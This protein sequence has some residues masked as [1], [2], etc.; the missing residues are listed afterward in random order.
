MLS[1]MQDYYGAT[2]ECAGQLGPCWAFWTRAGGA[3]VF[4]ETWPVGV[5]PDAVVLKAK[6]EAQSKASQSLPK[7]V[8]SAAAF[9]AQVTA[10]IV[11]SLFE[12]GFRT[13]TIEQFSTGP[14]PQFSKTDLNNAIKDTLSTY[15]KTVATIQ[16]GE[17]KKAFDAVQSLAA[18]S[19]SGVVMEALYSLLADYGIE[20]PEE[21]KKFLNCLYSKAGGLVF[22]AVKQAVIDGDPKGAAQL[23]APYAIACSAKTAKDSLEAGSI[24]APLIDAIALAAVVA[25]A[26]PPPPAPKVPVVDAKSECEQ[27]GGIVLKNGACFK[28]DEKVI[29]IAKYASSGE[30]LKT[31]ENIYKAAAEG[32]KKRAEEKK[33]QEE[34]QQM[35]LIAGAAVVAYLALS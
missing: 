24:W 33:K 15:F 13:T 14:C 21:V 2:T 26:P 8:A 10:P 22:T 31:Q 32:I 18:G 35:L 5:A 23:L 20:V 19:P 30:A 29:G 4:P 9:G 11:G 34:Q 25:T 16:G 27:T 7:G 1:A 17:A 28:F 12:K 3:L 6:Q